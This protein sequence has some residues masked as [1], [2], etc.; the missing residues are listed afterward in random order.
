[1][2]NPNAAPEAPCRAGASTPGLGHLIPTRA[3]SLRNSGRWRRLDVDDH[4]CEL[5]EAGHQLV[6]DDVGRRVR[7]IERGG[8]VEPEVQIEKGVVG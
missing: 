5:R 1:M 8:A 3:L 2:S 4:I 7:I 6:F